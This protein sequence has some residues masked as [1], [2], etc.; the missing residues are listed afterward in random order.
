[1]ILISKRIINKFSKKEFKKNGVVSNFKIWNRHS[2]L[3]VASPVIDYPFTILYSDDK[4]LI[5]RDLWRNIL[6][7]LLNIF[8]LLIIYY[9]SFYFNYLQ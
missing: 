1:M 3:V 2:N 8:T 7:F 6:P 4:N 9:K 5:Y